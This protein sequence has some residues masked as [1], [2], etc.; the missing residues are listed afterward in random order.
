MKASTAIWRSLL[1][2]MLVG[3]LGYCAVWAHNTFFGADIDPMKWG[4]LPAFLV[5][6]VL[7]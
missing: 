3:G 7:G 6:L 5:V 2:P 1:K 4:F